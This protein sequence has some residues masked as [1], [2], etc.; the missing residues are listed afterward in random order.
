MK[1]GGERSKGKAGRE[2]DERWRIGVKGE[3]EEVERP[4]PEGFF[5]KFRMQFSFDVPFLQT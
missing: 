5:S 2:E 1:G 4:E 3:E